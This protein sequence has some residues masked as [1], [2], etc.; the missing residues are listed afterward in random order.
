MDDY[1]IQ[2]H[3]R[4]AAW[5]NI[6]TNI[7]TAL[8]AAV[9]LFGGALLGLAS[10]DATAFFGLSGMGALLAVPLGFYGILGVL[11][12]IG[13]LQGASWARTLGIVISILHLIN[14]SSFGWTQILGI[15]TLIVLLNPAAQRY[16]R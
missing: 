15:Y 16:F 4:I 14:V 3:I 9:F 5:L 10:G 7:G 6:L 1:N 8:F 13:M 11:S 2:T 12:G